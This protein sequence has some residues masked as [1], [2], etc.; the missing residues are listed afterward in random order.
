MIKLINILKE[1][2]VFGR[3][4][5][6]PLIKLV[7]SSKSEVFKDEDKRKQ[8]L[9]VIERNLKNGKAYIGYDYDVNKILDGIQYYPATDKFVGNL[10]LSIFF[11]GTYS[12][13]SAVSIDRCRFKDELMKI[14]KDIEV[15][16][17]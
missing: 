3:G 7:W 6:S 14:S 11:K 15:K 9:R 12:Q 16:R 10:P 2:A 13:G 5:E 4:K 1:A 8:F 17:K